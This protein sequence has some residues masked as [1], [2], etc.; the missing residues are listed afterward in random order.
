MIIYVVWL[1]TFVE[2]NNTIRYTFDQLK[3]SSHDIGSYLGQPCAR[4][5]VFLSVRG[6]NCIGFNDFFSSAVP[7][8]HSTFVQRRNILS[9]SLINAHGHQASS[10]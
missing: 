2:T 7:W 9:C 6:A 10:T 8:S 5:L 3:M 1:V 4:L